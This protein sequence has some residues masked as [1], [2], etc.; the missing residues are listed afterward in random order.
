V[1][2]FFFCLIILGGVLV[3]VVVVVEEV[4]SSIRLIELDRRP[5]P[6]SFQFF[7]LISIFDRPPLGTFNSR[8]R[9]FFLFLP[10]QHKLLSSRPS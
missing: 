9:A 5:R 7:N 1:L 10:F 4:V 8:T 2:V 3:V 6:L